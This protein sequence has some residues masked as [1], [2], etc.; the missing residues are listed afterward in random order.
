MFQTI[1]QLFRH[2]MS[3]SVGL[4]FMLC[5]FLLANLATR[6]PDIKAS[7]H[8]SESDMDWA[9]LAMSLGG[10]T[11]M[12][13]TSWLMSKMGSGKANIFFA[14]AMCGV[15]LLPIFANTYTFLLIGLF[16]VG[17]SM[18]ALDVAMN[19]A[20]DAIEKV[21]AVKIMSTCHGMFS[22]GG[23]LGAFLASFLSGWQ[24]SKEGHMVTVI[25]LI[26]LLF[27]YLYRFL[28]KMPSIEIEEGVIFVLP[29]GP[30][31]IMGAVGFCI[32]MG[33]G[34]VSDWSAIYLKDTLLGN[35]FIVGLGIAG[36][37]LSM[38]IGR[39]YGDVVVPKYGAKRIVSLGS[40]LGSMGILL[41]IASSSVFLTLLGFTVVGLGF[42]CVVPVLFRNAA[43]VPTIASGTGVAAVT[44]FGILG[45]LVGPPTIGFVGEQFGLHIG[46]LTVALLG[47]I[48]YWLA[49]R[50][51]W[52]D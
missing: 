24:V 33:E 6:F 32:M 29:K 25:I 9:L 13:F 38:A 39:F 30:L 36:F 31:F 7:L 5:S 14:F 10:L 43:K 52:Y 41:A 12:P 15:M 22:L 28:L 45:F 23:M 44:T 47:I 4:V 1:S 3:R 48:A 16:L 2:P 8:L 19:A 40:L 34:A 37:S 49:L 51:V 46:F 11:I 20:T 21:Y 27:L 26:W 35:D 17:L 42:S 50:V 18:G